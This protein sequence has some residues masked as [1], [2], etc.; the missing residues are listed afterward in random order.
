M[1]DSPL[2]IVCKFRSPSILVGLSVKPFGAVVPYIQ[3]TAAACCCVKILVVQLYDI[4][5]S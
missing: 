5:Y 2:S 1:L 4:E 3:T